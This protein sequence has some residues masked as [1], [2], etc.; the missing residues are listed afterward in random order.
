[1][2]VS[3]GFSQ[4]KQIV[5]DE[6]F[7][8]T[9]IR[10]TKAILAIEINK[11][12]KETLNGSLNLYF[13]GISPTSSI[14]P[15]QVASFVGSE[16]F[17]L[18][19]FT[20]TVS[21]LTKQTTYYYNW[22]LELDDA[23]LQTGIN[24]FTTLD[25]FAAL[26]FQMYEIP[27]VGLKEG[28]KIGRI[29]YDDDGV[30]WKK[31]QTFFKTTMALKENGE[32]HA[33][34]RN[35][36]NLIPQIGGHQGK[37]SE[38]VYEPAGI[39][40]DPGSIWNDI[41]SD[42]DGYW[43]VDEDVAGTNKNSSS[44]VPQNDQDNDYFSDEFETLLGTNLEEA[45]GYED[46]MK[47][48][49]YVYTK[50]NMDQN[51]MKFHDFAFS[52]TVAFGITKEDTDNDGLE[53]R[54]LY[55]WGYVYGGL[56]GYPYIMDQ[57]GNQPGGKIPAVNVEKNMGYDIVFHQPTQ[58]PL[59]G[60]DANDALRQLRWEKIAVSDNFLNP[61]YPNFNKLENI[62]DATA[63]AITVDGD[64]Y[65]WG[66]VEG[67]IIFEFKRLGADRKWIDVTVG[68]NIVAI[69]ENGDMFSVM[70]L[71]I[72]SKPETS[73][74]DKDND[75]TSDSVDDFPWNKNFQTDTDGDGLPNKIE[76]DLGTNVNTPDTDGDGA[77]DSED[78]FPLSSSYELLVNGNVINVSGSEIKTDNDDDGLPA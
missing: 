70:D 50:L 12:V 31:V 49:K 33:F 3:Y 4:Q 15:T 24:S 67:V 34:G 52:K 53:D 1:M 35:A 59:S 41:D 78:A 32:L 39:I 58:F 37:G 77:I 27:E 25:G 64:L 42:N 63:A 76:F 8:A 46:W 44:S 17:N 45:G 30:Q 61:K 66:V 19:V 68:E 74:L 7:S 48:E 36:R 20:S 57:N 38:V 16:T 51:Y 40:K 72:P 13:H 56:D 28:D 29:K 6:D 71:N 73:N 11:A 69:D 60:S 21:G 55:G 10:S 18:Q 23:V 14:S 75:G 2:S 5:I 26:P 54:K 65:V 9:E 62:Y 43:N 22:K 47:F